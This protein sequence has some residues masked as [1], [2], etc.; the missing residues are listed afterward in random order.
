MALASSQAMVTGNHLMDFTFANLGI[1]VTQGEVLAIVL[2]AVGPVALAWGG[3]NY[4]YTA[5]NQFMQ[6]PGSGAFDDSWYNVGSTNQGALGF[7]T[8]VECADPSNCQAFVPPSYPV[9]GPIVGAGLPGLI[10]AGGGLLGW[11]RRKRKAAPERLA[12]YA[13]K[14]TADVP[15]FAGCCQAPA[16]YP[17]G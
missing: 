1:A 2:Q 16:N 11:W 13:N 6:Q 12:H 10:F 14:A 9:P 8:Y 4:P 15:G 17:A 5:G 3:P 7:Q